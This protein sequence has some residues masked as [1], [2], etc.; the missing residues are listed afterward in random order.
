[1]ISDKVFKT[2]D[3]FV[4]ALYS[5]EERL[6]KIREL[7]RIRGFGFDFETKYTMPEEEERTVEELE[8]D[9]QTASDDSV[10]EAEQRLGV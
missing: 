2:A 6:R 10:E 8:E 9:E 7:L 4:E 1:M 5:D 3:E